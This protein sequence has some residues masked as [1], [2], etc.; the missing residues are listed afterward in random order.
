MKCRDWGPVGCQ[1]KPF[2]CLKTV[3]V[4]EHVYVHV[5]ALVHVVVDGFCGEAENVLLDTKTDMLI[6]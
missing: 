2:I 4:Y 1:G 5:D 3:H 6:T